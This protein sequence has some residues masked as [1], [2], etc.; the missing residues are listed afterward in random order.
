MF[1]SELRTAR[2]GYLGQIR[3]LLV[4]VDPSAISELREL[5]GTPSADGSA[6][7]EPDEVLRAVLL[8]ITKKRGPLDRIAV[9][10]TK[11]DLLEHSI[12]GRPDKSDVRAWLIARGL[13]AMVNLVEQNARQDVRYAVSD[14]TVHD[15]V[16][17]RADLLLW[18][19]HEDRSR[20]SLGRRETGD[21]LN[22]GGSNAGDPPL[23]YRAGR[24]GMM[25]SFIVG[26]LAVPV[27]AAILL[28]RLALA[29]F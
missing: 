21:R 11:G 27:A 12:A 10:V 23:V 16:A 7:T 17:A 20:S 19:A 3:S 29:V 15:T 9:V 26:S 6:P 22:L 5:V 24:A 25:A 14:L 2:L 1:S 13:G 18:L 4:I 28:T 8:T